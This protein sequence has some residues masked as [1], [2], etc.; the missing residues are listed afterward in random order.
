MDL[1]DIK[2]LA[3]VID[4]CRK[5]GIKAFELPGKLRLELGDEP[6][7]KSRKNDENQSVEIDPANRYANFPS[8]NLTPEQLTFYSAGGMPENDPA[9]KGQ[10]Q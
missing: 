10:D 7:P 8:G 9:L 3:K 2:D 6:E 1:P 5:K 4:L